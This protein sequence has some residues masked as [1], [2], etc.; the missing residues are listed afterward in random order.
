M[1]CN[2]Q[3][4]ANIIDLI[5]KFCIPDLVSMDKSDK[6]EYSIYILQI[7][8]RQNRLF[9]KYV[10]DNDAYHL[11]NVLIGRKIM[12]QVYNLFLYIC[13]TPVIHQVLQT[14]ITLYTII[15]FC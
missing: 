7:H 5:Q 10:N 12:V 8:L 14:K 9:I 13:I 6:G 1:C 11:W 3:L 15:I 4:I 2:I